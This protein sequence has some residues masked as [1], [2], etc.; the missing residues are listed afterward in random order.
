MPFGRAP[1]TPLADV[2][3]ASDSRHHLP[4]VVKRASARDVSALRAARRDNPRG[5]G[6][7]SVKA[8]NGRAIWYRL[9]QGVISWYALDD[10]QERTLLSSGERRED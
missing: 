3:W 5:I 1:S 10:E 7:R 9:H 8:A 2:F 4:P 6:R